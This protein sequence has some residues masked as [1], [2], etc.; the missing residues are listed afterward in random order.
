MKYNRKKPI[1]QM[2][3]SPQKNMERGANHLTTPALKRENPD[4]CCKSECRGQTN[5]PRKLFPDRSFF[6]LLPKFISGFF[7]RSATERIRSRYRD[8]VDTNAGGVYVTVELDGNFPS[9]HI[10]AGG[11]PVEIVGHWADNLPKTIERV[12]DQ[13][14]SI[15]KCRFQYLRVIKKNGR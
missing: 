6:K 14:D 4:T 10:S 7:R 1:S 8:P 15:S 2:E 5:N 11:N 13:L 3:M 12:I 9:G